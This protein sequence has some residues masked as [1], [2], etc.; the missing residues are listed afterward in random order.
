MRLSKICRDYE[1]G[2]QIV[3][4]LD[5]VDLE[6]ADGEYMS[7]MGPSPGPGRRPDSQLI[8]G[9]QPVPEYYR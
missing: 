3:H 5:H 6:I 4:A 2:D 8:A 9:H 1:V 7:I